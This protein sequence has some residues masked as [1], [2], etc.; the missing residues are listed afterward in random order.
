MVMDICHYAVTEPAIL[1]NPFIS[2]QRLGIHEPIAPK[3]VHR[4]V[5]NYDFLFMVFYTPVE[6]RIR[7]TCYSCKPNTLMIWEPHQ[8]HWYGNRDS[9]WNH[10][11]IHLGGNCTER[12]VKESGIAVNIPQPI[13]NSYGFVRFIQ[14]VLDEI[15]GYVIPDPEILECAL[16]MCLRDFIRQTQDDGAGTIPDQFLAV[17]NML[18][19]RFQEQFTLNQLARSTNLSKPQ[20]CARFKAHFGTSA[21]DYLIRIRMEHASFL[22]RDINMSVKEMAQ[23]V[24][25]DDI[26]YFSKLFK[27]YFGMSPRSY[28]SRLE[29]SS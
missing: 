10:S 6:L 17:K 1:N 25:Y 13:F 26:Y 11:W 18:E 15:T 2:G 28:R 29:S 22:L 16:K 27:K 3:I 7:D 8:P 20:F 23:A 5:G 24:G 9:E 14:I 21:I 12:L 4:P 19:S